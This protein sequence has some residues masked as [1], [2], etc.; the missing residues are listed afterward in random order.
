MELDYVA[1]G[2]RIR[3]YRKGKGF[4]QV[5]LAKQVG[6]EPSN[7]SH[8][9]RAASKV[10]LGTLVKIANTLECTVNDLVC[11]SLEYERHSYENQLVEITKDCSPEDL[12]MI[13]NM[14]EALR[15]NLKRWK[16]AHYSHSTSKK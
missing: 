15:E 4:T 13:V 1:L 14:V 2:K 10:S 16:K 7:I 8:I 3:S 6:I 12:R 11:D 5:Y 9:E